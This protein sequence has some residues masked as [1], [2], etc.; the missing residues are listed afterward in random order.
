MIYT[1]T[2]NPSLD[3]IVRLD[4]F[5]TGTINRTKYEQILGGLFGEGAN[6]MRRDF[7]AHL[8]LQLANLR[9]KLVEDL[10]S[11]LGEIDGG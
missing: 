1:V 2:F 8:N 10:A 6:K 5:E 7:A 9:G 11:D 3:Y 4:H